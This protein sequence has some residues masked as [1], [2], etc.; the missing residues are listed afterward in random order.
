MN[1][2]LYG[3]TGIGIGMI[4]ALLGMGGGFLFVPFF[5]YLMKMDM[6]QA[7]GT[8]VTLIVPTALFASIG[9]FQNGNVDMKVALGLC[10]F[11]IIGSYCGAQ[12]SSHIP[13]YILR[14]IFALF[15]AVVALKM[16]FK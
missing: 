6:H 12:L 11:C 9:Y 3:L 10:I 1:Y 5:V 7:I 14:K 4:G 16:F 8:S 2:L 15:L 13:A